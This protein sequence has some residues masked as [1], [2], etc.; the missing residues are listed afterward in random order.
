VK[1]NKAHPS[2]TKLVTVV[3]VDGTFSADLDNAVITN[4]S[5]ADFN[6]AVATGKTPDAGVGV[7]VAQLLRHWYAQ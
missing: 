7:S 3:I 6:D 2:S 4:I 1:T 5:E